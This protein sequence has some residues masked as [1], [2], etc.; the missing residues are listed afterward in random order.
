VA[1]VRTDVSEKLS[2]SI[3]L[4]FFAACV[5]ASYGYVRSSPIPV[6]LMMEALNSSETFVL[7]RATQ[8]NITEDDILNIYGGFDFSFNV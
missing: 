7:T 2:A 5:V 1:L 6:N 8:R 4:Y 3:T